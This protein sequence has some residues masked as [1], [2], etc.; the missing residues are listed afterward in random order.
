MALLFHHPFIHP[1]IH[2]SISIIYPYPS[3]IHIHPFIHIH[4]SIHIHHLSISIIYPYPSY[5][6]IHPSIHIHPFVHNIRSYTYSSLFFSLVPQQDPVFQVSRFHRRH[7]TCH[8]ARRVTRTNQEARTCQDPQ[9]KGTRTHQSPPHRRGTR[10]HQDPAK[11]PATTR[12]KFQK[13]RVDCSSLPLAVL[14][15]GRA[16]VKGQIC[17]HHHNLNRKKE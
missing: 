12:H 11:T 7:L 17:Q 13:T 3:Y 16:K 9:H 5:I 14:A 1:S 6:H 10:I 4:P 2:L 8:K 15:P